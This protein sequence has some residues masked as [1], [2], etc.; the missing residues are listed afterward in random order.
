MS[1]RQLAGLGL[2]ATLTVLAA[3]CTA[4]PQLA[5]PGPHTASPA[6]S[7]AGGPAQTPSVLARQGLQVPPPT[8]RACAGSASVCLN[9]PAGPIPAVLNR[10]LRFPALRPGQ[11][12]PQSHGSGSPVTI[13]DDTGTEFGNG[14]V[15]V[16]IGA[17]RDG[18]AGLLAHTRFPPW[19][20]FKTAWVSVPAYQGP[21]RDPRQ[22][23]GPSRP[24]LPGDAAGDGADRRA[25]GTDDRH[26]PAQQQAAGLPHLPGGILGQV[27]RVLRLAG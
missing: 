1:R 19:L 12:C 26:H 4:A 24:G 13:A 25:A 22:A 20:G 3:A 14:P 16:L 5:A 17:S 18:V 6:P 21:V 10:P 8:S 11:R 23:A 15:R 27:S 9:V 7:R 2:V